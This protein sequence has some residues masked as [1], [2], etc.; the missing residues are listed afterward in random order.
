MDLREKLKK[1]KRCN[2]HVAIKHDVLN[3]NI[4]IKIYFKC[5]QNLLEG[6]EPVHNGTRLCDRKR[7]YPFC[8]VVPYA[9]KSC[10]MAVDHRAW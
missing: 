2:F 7:S 8:F 4:Y 3:V 9:E 5:R 6:N 10:S 1:K